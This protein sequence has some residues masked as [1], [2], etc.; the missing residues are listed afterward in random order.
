MKPRLLAHL[1]AIAVVFALTPTL[2]NGA[3][4]AGPCAAGA[5]YDSACDVD[6]DGDVDI[7]DIQLTAGHWN[8]SGTWSGGG[9][10][11]SLTGNAGTNP[12]SNFLGT[13]DDQP[14]VVKV[15]GQRALLV[16][17]ASDPT[18]APSIIGGYTGNSSSVDV[19]GATIAGGGNDRNTNII[20]DHYGTIAGGV[21]NLAGDGDQI[22]DDAEYATVGGGLIN[23]ASGEYSTVAGGHHN[24]ATNWESTVGGGLFNTASGLRSTVGGGDH[25]TAGG[26]YSTTGGGDHNSASGDYGAVGGGSF[27]IASGDYSAV[28]GGSFNV[29]SGDR[30]TVG[31]GWSN[32]ASG[33]YSA[34]S[35][36]LNNIAA[37]GGSIVPGGFLNE[38][39]GSYSFAAGRMA[40][41]LADGSFVWADN[42]GSSFTANTP[43][44]FLVRAQNGA[45]FDTNNIGYA[46]LA[47]N[48]NALGQGLRGATDG[49]YAGYF[50]DDIFVAGQCTGCLL[51]YVAVN[52]NAGTLA[53]GDLVAPAGLA[54]PLAGS[55]AAVLRVQ[56][57]EA[58]Q[59]VVGVVTAR[60]ALH[61]AAMTP[62]GATEQVAERAEGAIQPG[63]YLFIAVQG[64]APVRIAAGETVAPGQRLTSAGAGQARAV[65]QLQIDGVAVD[66]SAP[67]V[68]IVVEAPDPA[69]G[70]AQ[71]MVSLR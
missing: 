26:E 29:A 65:R 56:R 58:G 11:W 2:S 33:D 60:A 36:G 54:A 57:A 67:T 21:G 17:P 8:R 9:D 25:N 16:R 69:T 42:Q 37:G 28:S 35:G 68:G 20:A 4:A 66:E 31:G 3:G 43:N 18:Q 63:D 64:L 24:A 50:E 38:A 14:L 34:V 7:F 12:A 46:L 61:S 47:F 71:V 39:S 23:F 13:S 70:L 22:R 41:A 45:Y 49:T 1:T 52:A 6:H 48:D 55:G 19:W 44:Q 30:S 62:T 32:T 15:N 5:L 10:G 51:A 27:N 40:K 53:V 59:G